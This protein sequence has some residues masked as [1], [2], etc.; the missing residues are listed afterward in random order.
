[1]DFIIVCPFARGNMAYQGVAEQDVYDALADVQ[2]RY[3][4]DEDRIYITGS[5]TGGG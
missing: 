5:S 2:R 4:V 3:A 1:V